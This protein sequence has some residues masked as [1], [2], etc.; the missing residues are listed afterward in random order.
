VH[1]LDRWEEIPLGTNRQLDLEEGFILLASRGEGL[2]C[3]EEPD[4]VWDQRGEGSATCQT[5]KNPGSNSGLP[6]KAEGETDHLPETA[7][8]HLSG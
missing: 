5:G 7:T 4:E 3:T 6:Q 2:K 8:N 1:P